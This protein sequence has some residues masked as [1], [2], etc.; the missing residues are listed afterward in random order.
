MACAALALAA[1]THEFDVARPTRVADPMPPPPNALGYSH[2][3]YSGKPQYLAS[4][5]PLHPTT[6][7]T[8]AAGDNPCATRSQA[9]E[10]RLRALL[11]SLDGQIL[12]LSTPPTEL[13]LSALRLEVAQLGPLLAPYPDIAAEGEELGT[14]V[15][16]LPSL[17]VVDVGPARRRMTEL[18]DLIRVQLAAGE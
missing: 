15:D 16:K 11:A 6:K 8:P 4:A 10:D 13:Q 7:A 14:V 9:C 3:P 12:A 1:C 17:T 18:S 2:A 5:R